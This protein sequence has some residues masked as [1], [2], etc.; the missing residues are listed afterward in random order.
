MATY[1]EQTKSALKTSEAATNIIKA[2]DPLSERSKRR[3]LLFFSDLVQDPAEDCTFAQFEI[4]K[5][6]AKHLG[7][8][9]LV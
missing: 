2:L 6:V 9:R 5:E 3:V 8:E 4:L 7:L 1:S